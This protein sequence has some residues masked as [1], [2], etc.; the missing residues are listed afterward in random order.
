MYKP[1]A[2]KLVEEFVDHQVE[3]LVD[4]RIGTVGALIKDSDLL[5]M[6]LRI[7]VERDSDDGKVKFLNQLN[8]KQSLVDLR[9]M[10]N[11]IADIVELDRNECQLRMQTATF[12]KNSVSE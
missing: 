12:T 5:G 8:G 1:A 10:V 9:A 11:T 6:P 4:D 3:S 7:A 2:D